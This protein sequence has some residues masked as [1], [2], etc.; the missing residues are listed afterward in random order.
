MAADS[1]DVTLLVPITEPMRAKWKASMSATRSFN[2][3]L[4]LSR[5]PLR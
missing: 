3:S 2:L 5:L 1:R 4:S